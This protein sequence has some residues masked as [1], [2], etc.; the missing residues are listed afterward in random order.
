MKKHI[1]YI[2]I[3]I[4][5]TCYFIF[6]CLHSPAQTCSGGFGDLAWKQTFGKGLNPGGILSPAKTK[7][8]FTIDPCPTDGYYAIVNSVSKC[9]SNSWDTVE[10]CCTAGDINGYMMLVN[11]SANPGDVYVDTAK[12]LCGSTHYQ[13]SATIVN[14]SNPASCGGHPINPRLTFSVET[15]SGQ[16]IS[17][18]S[19]GDIP[20]SS[21]GTG[22]NVFAVYF[23]TPPGVDAVVVRIS[24]DA[25]GGCG[26]DFALD[27][28][29]VGTCGPMLEAGIKDMAGTYI[30][31]CVGAISALELVGKLGAGYT[32]PAYQWQSYNGT[33]WIDIPGASGISYTLNPPTIAG[34]Y[35]Y[36]ITA[37][38]KDNIASSRCRIFSSEI[39]INIHNPSSA[40]SAT[41]NSPVC[42]N[43]VINL[44]ADGGKSYQW[45]GPAGF[46]SNESNPS[47]IATNSSAGQ[48]T[49]NI[50]D[51]YGCVNKVTTIVSTIAAPTVVVSE[52]KNICLGDSVNL[53]ASGG[54]VYA[55]TPVNYLSNASI[56]NP[57]AKPAQTTV[58]TVMV[59]D[60]NNCSDT[61][62]VL[63]VINTKPLVSAGEDKFIL[64]G[65]SVT[66][67]GSI[68]DANNV[69]F[70]WTA[71]SSLKNTDVLNPEA[72][73]VVSTDYILTAT[74]NIGCGFSS[75]TVSVT[76]Y[77]GLS[78]PNAFSPNGDGRNDVWRIPALRVYPNAA[79]SVYNRYG[80]KVF[81][82]SGGSSWNGS[83]KN[84]PQPTGAYA[85]TIDLRNG[86]P[87]IKGTVVLVR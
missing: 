59:T 73:P 37:A 9:F 72:N 26:N 44:S 43:S 78:I 7:Y 49:V 1:T 79:I 76:V 33:D 68:Q 50:S 22:P 32:D 66:L 29:Y 21:S 85:Y 82:G 24:D 71:S 2:S 84:S 25:P 65:Q 27:N 14:V 30:D 61:A 83:Y 74:S 53:Q 87:V 41:S 19:T 17:T 34:N 57:I 5:I 81:E 55:W 35:K 80:Q 86:R 31:L 48:Y 8:K 69:N 52:T 39:N 38:E 56:N 42:V 60:N 23:Y 62:S 16:K 54:N 4:V 6:L 3:K 45:T 75:D 46:T 64:K 58:Y 18:Y 10:T 28:L 67:D 12:N 20:P 70:S 36:R 40:G 51:A 15:I 13:F 63:V 47:F 77:N 11:A